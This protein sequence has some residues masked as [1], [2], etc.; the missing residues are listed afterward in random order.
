MPHLMLG[1]GRE[2]RQGQE[3]TCLRAHRPLVGKSAPDPEL[4]RFEFWFLSFVSYLVSKL[5]FTPL[6]T[7]I[8]K[9]YLY[10]A[11]KI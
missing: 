4:W 2:L 5:Q 9:V 10:G 3:A 11:V 8:I 6:K 7:R 1:L